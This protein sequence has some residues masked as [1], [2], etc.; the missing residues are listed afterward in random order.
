M[1]NKRFLTEQLIT[2][3]GNKRTLLD[4][5]GQG[6][7][8][9]K[10][11]LKKDKLVTFDGFAGSGVVSRYL[12][13]HSSHLITNDFEEYSWVINQSF[14][15]NYSELDYKY[16][17]NK[18]KELNSLK[19]RTDLGTG[20]IEELYSPKDDDNIQ[21]GE[22]VFYSNQNAKIIDNLRRSIDLVV[23][24]EEYKK[25]FLSAL[26]S[27]ASVHV[28]T[29]GVFKGFYK[30]KGIDIGQFGG[31]GQN[32]LGRILKE[33][34][35]EIPIFSNHTCTYKVFNEDT[36]ELIKRIGYDIDI[37]VVYY[38]PPYNQHPYGSNYHMLNTIL[39][40]ERPTKISETAGIPDDWQ[41]SSYNKKDSSIKSLDELIKNTK[42]S[43][44]LLSYN[45]EGII[46]HDTVVE[47]MN[48]Y[49]KLQVLE[50]EYCT[51][52]ASKN[53]SERSKTVSEILYVLK[54]KKGK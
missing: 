8:I 18:T 51:Y 40:Y 49:G 21:P 11:D 52:K 46:P 9:A 27:K 48:K 20:I 43:Y 14:L 23:D 12:K 16:I 6:I 36:N 29:G 32:S 41:R 15:S 1:E 10:T 38:D 2:Y 54:K 13:Q 5:I 30:K 25:Y 45:N 37:D 26:L 34:E 47:I 42:A 17:I 33:I 53:L 44:I 35:L 7:E 31:E 19:L 22:R 4:F 28:N 39:R 50:K 3:I 24:K